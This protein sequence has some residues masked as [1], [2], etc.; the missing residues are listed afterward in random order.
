LSV[1]VCHDFIEENKPKKLLVMF[2]QLLATSADS[3]QL[4]EPCSFFW[5]N[6]PLL[7]HEWYFPVPPL[8]THDGICEWI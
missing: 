5:I 3:G 4:P 1:I 2:Q 6:S 7:T 8:L